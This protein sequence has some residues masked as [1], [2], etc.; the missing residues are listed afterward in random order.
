[1]KKILDL[2]LKRS[3]TQKLQS[4]QG[5]L[6]QGKFADAHQQLLALKNQRDLDLKDRFKIANMLPLIDQDQQA[7]ELFRELGRGEDPRIAK[8]SFSVA[9]SIHRRLQQPELAIDAAI[10]SCALGGSV[11]WSSVSRLL[12][13]CDDAAAVRLRQKMNDLHPSE[14]YPFYKLF[15]LIENRLS[16][17]DSSLEMMKTSARLGF[18]KRKSTVPWDE[19]NP[20]L[21][22]SFI[23]IGGMKCGSTTLF[24][25]IASH[26]KCL[27]P[28]EKELQFF[29]YPELDPD[30]YFQHFPRAKSGSGFITG[31]GSPGYFAY[32]IVGRVKSLLPNVKLI[33]V[34][35]DPVARAISHLRHNIRYG[36]AGKG[37]AAVLENVDALQSAICDNPAE[38]EETMR[39]LFRGETSFSNHFLA[40]GCYEILL[41]RWRRQF[42]GQLLELELDEFQANP[43]AVMNQVFEFLELEPVEVPNESSNVGQ[44][45]RSD[46]ETERVM[47]RLREFYSQVDQAWGS[48]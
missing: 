43:V 14:K 19:S 8:K 36:M 45:S 39:L 41:G 32:D 10:E 15:S 16:N 40:L 21:R 27:S 25:Q 35:R 29:Q 7:I 24:N 17:S 37:V 30:W 31:E 9:M 22:P 20:L 47:E 18:G 13:D 26:P 3:P 28:L 23:V 46:A 44:Y 33:F 42:S 34:R 4:I 6:D 48:R 2:F 38:A 12:D 5:L 1:M 11:P